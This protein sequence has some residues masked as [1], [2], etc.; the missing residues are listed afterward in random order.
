MQIFPFPCQYCLWCLDKLGPFLPAEHHNSGQKGPSEPSSCCIACVCSYF[1]FHKPFRC[2]LQTHWGW[3]YISALV[4]KLFRSKVLWQ[5]FIRFHLCLCTSHLAVWFSCLCCWLATSTCCA[6]SLM[7]PSMGV[8][9]GVTSSCSF[10][11]LQPCLMRWIPS[12]IT[13]GFFCCWIYLSRT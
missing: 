2:C 3:W 13:P 9:G 10:H 1:P 11:L 6:P 4:G 8:V 7:L 5:S 12:L